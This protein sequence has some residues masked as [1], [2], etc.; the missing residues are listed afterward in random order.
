M[1]KKKLNNDPRRTLEMDKAGLKERERE[2]E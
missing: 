2:R 1:K